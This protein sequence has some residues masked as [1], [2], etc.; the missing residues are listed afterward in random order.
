LGDHC[1]GPK[2]CVV[3]AREGNAE[4]WACMAPG[5]GQAFWTWS[6]NNTKTF[7]TS[8]F[9]GICATACLLHWYPLLQALALVYWGS[10]AANTCQHLTGQ[11]AVVGIWQ[12]K[13]WQTSLMFLRARCLEEEPLLACSTAANKTGSCNSNEAAHETQQWALSS[14]Y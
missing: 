2:P 4:E 1:W 12:G 9:H 3:V 13:R 5:W 7:T 8:H 11:M 10:K 14:S 6:A